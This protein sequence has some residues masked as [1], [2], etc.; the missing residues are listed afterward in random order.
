MT[1]TTL[2]LL[3]GGLP[4]SWWLATT[5]WRGRVIVEAIVSLPL[6]LPPTVT[7]QAPHIPVP[8][9]MMGLRLT[10]VLIPWGRVTLDTTR[11]MGTGPMATT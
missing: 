10:S 6:V 11:I 1:F 2:I 4:L 5:R 8:S 9:T 3:V 7:R